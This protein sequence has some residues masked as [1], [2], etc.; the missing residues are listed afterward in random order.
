[1]YRIFINRERER[2][3]ELKKKIREKNMLFEYVS[4]CCMCCVRMDHDCLI[5]CYFQWMV[6]Q[7]VEK[8][9]PLNICLAHS[10]VNSVIKKI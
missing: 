7:T 10:M 8:N 5:K 4:F 3:R 9:E 2:G 6:E 1:M